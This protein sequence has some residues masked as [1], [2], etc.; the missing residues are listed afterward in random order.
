MAEN[1]VD[2]ARAMPNVKVDSRAHLRDKRAPKRMSVHRAPSSSVAFDVVNVS[3]Y[4]P[5]AIVKE[6]GS[7]VV[8]SC[9]G[10][11]KIWVCAEGEMSDAQ[12]ETVGRL[13]LALSA[14][15]PTV[16]QGEDLFPI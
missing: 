7:A 12:K 14:M 11:G 9:G 6:D 8:M 16:I 5:V 10:S 15:S 2:Y 4:C 3:D 13:M 1:L